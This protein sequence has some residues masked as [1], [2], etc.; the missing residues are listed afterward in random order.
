VAP[1]EVA[2]GTLVITNSGLEQRL[3]VGATALH[4]GMILG[5][6]SRCSGNTSVMTN[7]VSRVHALVIAI[8]DQ[9]HIIDAGSTNGVSIVTRHEHIKCEPVDPNVTYSLGGMSVRWEPKY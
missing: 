6:Y 4:R 1:G 8:G 3:L 7:L 2:Q 5:R 9:V